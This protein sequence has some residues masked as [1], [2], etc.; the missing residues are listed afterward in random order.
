MFTSLVVMLNISITTWILSFFGFGY[1][2][3]D[4]LKAVR[5]GMLY[6]VFQIFGGYRERKFKVSEDLEKMVKDFLK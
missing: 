6:W 3:L 2:V 5:K 4:V 1:K